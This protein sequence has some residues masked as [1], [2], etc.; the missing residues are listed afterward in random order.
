M[1][2]IPFGQPILVGHHSEGKHRAHIKKVDRLLSASVLSDSKA[3]Y[4]EAKVERME[5]DA[6]I[7]SDDPEAIVKLK[8]KIGS[9]EDCH[10]KMVLANK[11]LR[12]GNK[13]GLSALGFSEE[14]IKTLSE[15]DYMGHIGFPSYS[16]S[17]SSANISRMKKRVEELTKLSKEEPE[18][19]ESESFKIVKSIELNRIQCFFE[20]S[21]LEAR[22]YLKKYAFRWSPRNG[23][24]QRHISAPAMR[25]AKEAMSIKPE[26]S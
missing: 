6:T 13:E 25:Y 3:A 20:K 5:K 18:E 23:C 9:A 14:T 2:Q 1:G 12:I 10:K 24:W 15:K 17:N 8:K 7:F 16:L 4:Y 22:D 19:I 21:N 26:V 11:L